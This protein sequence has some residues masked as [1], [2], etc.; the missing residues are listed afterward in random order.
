[1]ADAVD[2]SCREYVAPR[3]F[4]VMDDT[5]RPVRRQLHDTQP[6]KGGIRD[7]YSTGNFK[8]IRKGCV[9]EFGQVCGGWGNN[10][11]IRDADNKIRSKTRVKITWLTHKF[12][13]KETN[14]HLLCK[15][16]A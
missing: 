13:I 10:I 8:G 14:N 1:L 5:Y 16:Y 4:I 7:K 6:A 12:K 3:T 2:S 15:F 9:C 11:K